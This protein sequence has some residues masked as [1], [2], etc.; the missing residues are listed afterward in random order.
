MKLSE[1]KGKI[2]DFFDNITSE[3]LLELS[4]EKY[5]FSTVDFSISNQSF[6]SK[7]LSI[8]TLSDAAL[9]SFNTNI[10][11]SEVTAA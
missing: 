9:S 8:Y 6:E 7:A 5:G 4:I 3:E 11:S 2:D 10:S 1:V